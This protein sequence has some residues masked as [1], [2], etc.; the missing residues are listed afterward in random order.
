M[1]GILADLRAP[2]MTGWQKQSC[3]TIG[4]AFSF[5]QLRPWNESSQI[6]PNGGRCEYNQTEAQQDAKRKE[7][8]YK[9]H[10]LTCWKPIV[11][12]CKHIYIHVVVDMWK[13][14]V[15][16]SVCSFCFCIIN[17]NTLGLDFFIDYF[18]TFKKRNR[19]ILYDDLQLV[20]TSVWPANG[21][22]LNFHLFSNSISYK[23]HL[24]TI[25]NV[26]FMIKKNTFKK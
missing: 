9:T 11:P 23:I 13:W 6:L 25:V 1:F 5:C 22:Y 12:L 10:R 7:A 19:N 18:F 15:A 14:K 4:L 24:K 3:E 20:M 16:C 21:D 2:R 26:T 8:R 17:L